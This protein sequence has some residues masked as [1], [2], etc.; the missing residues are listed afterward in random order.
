MS[1]TGGTGASPLEDVDVVVPCFNGERHLART[2]ET[3]FSQTRPPASVLV[4]DD[5]S[6]DATPRVVASFGG[7]VGYVR[8]ENG[9]QASARNLGLS[10]TSNPLV[11]LLDADDLLAPTMLETLARRLADQPAADLAHADVLG[12]FGDDADHPNAEAWRPATAWPSY[13]EALS[14][15]C[16]FHGS[17]TVFRRR[18]F[19]MHG[20]FPEARTLQGCEDWHFFLRAAL[21]GAVVERVA[22][23]LCLYRYHPQASSSSGT[24]VARREAELARAAVGLFR[25]SEGRTRDEWAILAAGVASIAA[26]WI[27]IGQ[28]DRAAELRALAAS[29]A[30]AGFVLPEPAAARSR[31]AQAAL[32]NLGLAD[33]LLGL[34][35]PVL[36]A[37]MALRVRDWSEVEGEAVRLGRADALGRVT[38]AMAGLVA[39]ELRLAASGGA[40]S[41][42]THLATALGLVHRAAGREAQARA[43][44]EDACRL[45]ANAAWPVLELLAGDVASGHWGRAAR[46]WR[47]FGS[48]DA[49]PCRLRRFARAA[50][51]RVAQS[52]PGV[53]EAARRVASAVLSIRPR[54]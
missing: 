29:V 45:D 44:F 9:G 17:A 19:E 7:R 5:G 32:L 54:S 33:A 47:A 1:E 18:V 8:K 24:A 16:A 40:A 30:P 51:V 4:V 37:V 52:H 23:P 22:R 43:S 48:G 10:L 15:L 2:L 21:G 46:R 13:V 42:A 35:R 11:C 20:G 41:Y 50:V 27:P 31:T 3:V 12:F 53:R 49:R 25:E 28:P 34:G 14:L 38:T 6:T 26:R 39:D 36:A